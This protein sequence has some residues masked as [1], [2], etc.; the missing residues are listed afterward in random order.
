MFNNDRFDKIRNKYSLPIN[1]KNDDTKNTSHEITINENKNSDKLEKIAE[2]GMIINKVNDYYL[3][4]LNNLKKNKFDEKYLFMEILD[5]NYFEKI[6][7]LINEINK[8]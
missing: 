8:N 4:T 1:S 7:K 5:L 6:S 2:L 3:D